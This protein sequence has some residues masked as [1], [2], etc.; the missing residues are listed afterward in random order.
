MRGK[1]MESL[2][3]N[4]DYIEDSVDQTGDKSGAKD[5]AHAHP[6]GERKTGT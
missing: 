6:D 5:E 4:P 3:K 2:E 1:E